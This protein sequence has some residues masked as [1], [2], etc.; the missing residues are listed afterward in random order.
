MNRYIYMMCIVSIVI[1][2]PILGA[3][4]PTTTPVNPVAVPPPTATEV[5][6]ATSSVSSPTPQDVAWVKVVEAAKKE[7]KLVLYGSAQIAGAYG[8]AVSQAFKERYGIS[9][10][11]LVAAGRQTVER[12]K[13]E[14]A[15][16]R[17]VGDVFFTGTPSATEISELKLATKVWPELP[18]LRDMNI[19]RND[20]RFDPEGEILFFTFG[21][22]GPF[23]NTKLIGP[24]D[25][26]RSYMDFLHPRYK[27]MVIINPPYD[28]GAG[29]TFFSAMLATKALDE[30][31]FRRFAAMEPAIWIGGSAEMYRMVAVGEYLAGTYATED[32][33]GPLITEGA[34]L[35]L[36]GMK[37]GNIARGNVLLVL[38]K[39]AHPNA[40]RL[41]ADWMFSS[42]GQTVYSKAGGITP[43]RKDVPDFLH[44]SVR[45][46][47]EPG[48]ILVRSW[49]VMQQE[50]K[51]MDSGIA[52]AIFGKK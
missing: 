19:F 44:P 47:P 30:N 27:K 49:D 39:A 28:L 20:P 18:T 36:L 4:S 22:S 13:V 23:I 17:P 42:E 14:A 21:L 43:L 34:P 3:C 2:I 45:V 32:G 25:E 37:E 50:T 46:T 15:M 7:G 29:A 33:L 31:Y 12:V 1:L 16:N 51:I 10:E 6:T 26:P 24:G 52:T 48:K 38:K 41:F 8:V 9:V 40:A 5:V 35:K 11:I